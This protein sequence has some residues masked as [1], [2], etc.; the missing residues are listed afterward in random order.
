LNDSNILLDVV[1]L[2]LLDGLL[3]SLEKKRKTKGKAVGI[4][5]ENLG[6]LYLML[7]NGG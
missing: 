1:I 3:M 5:G 7:E 6:G 2:G 4:V